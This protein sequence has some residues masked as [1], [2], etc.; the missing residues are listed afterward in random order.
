LRR[1]SS[2]RLALSVIDA[3]LIN[4]SNVTDVATNILIFLL[5]LVAT[6]EALG[7]ILGVGKFDEDD[8]YANLDWLVCQGGKT[9]ARYLLR[10]SYREDG[11]VKHRTIANLRKPSS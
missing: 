7:K 9:Y 8:L 3:S 4:E 2:T 11:K 10:E 6:S 1:V 5:T